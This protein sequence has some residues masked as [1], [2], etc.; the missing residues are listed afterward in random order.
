MTHSHTDATLSLL[1]RERTHFLAEVDRVP[2]PLRTRRIEPD[3]WSVAEIVEHVALVD[4]GAT[5]LLQAASAG[6]L[7]PATGPA[8][9]GSPLPESVVAQVHDRTTRL[10]APERVRP[11]GA[12]SLDDAMSGLA[13]SRAALIDAYRAAAADVL[14]GVAYPHPFL[15]SLTLRG[16][17]E[18]SAH[19]DARHAQQV[20]ELAAS[21]ASAGA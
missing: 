20:A 5:R 13:Q 14:D 12:L 18:A 2:P 19:H 11:T 7:P 17:V 9:T 6:T 15:G 16:W 10:Q 1:D 3:R 4:R 21:A 8:P